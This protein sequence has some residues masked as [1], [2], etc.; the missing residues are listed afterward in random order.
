MVPL[1]HPCLLRRCSSR[2]ADFS[3]PI[4][5]DGALPGAIT[6]QNSGR[7]FLRAAGNTTTHGRASVG[8]FPYP[9]QTVESAAFFTPVLPRRVW[10]ELRVKLW[11]SLFLLPRPPYRLVSPERTVDARAN[12][13]NPS[14]A[15][16]RRQ[17]D[18]AAEFRRHNTETFPRRVDHR[19]MLVPRVRRI[20]LKQNPPRR[21]HRRRRQRFVRDGVLR[22]NRERF[23]CSSSERHAHQFPM[24]LLGSLDVKI[25]PRAINCDRI[26][27]RHRH[28]LCPRVL[29]ADPQHFPVIAVINPVTG[30]RRGDHG[31]GR[32]VE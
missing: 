25:R 4:P 27:F 20:N 12:G 5:G 28:R 32:R 10:A 21:I 1:S 24:P 31:Y 17:P 3:F 8:D 19:H 16:P 2:D 15:P 6:N 9:S 29:S 18:I 13:D 7:G 11:P 23:R 22:W 30:W 14:V 26:A